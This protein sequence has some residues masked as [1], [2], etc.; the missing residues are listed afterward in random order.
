MGDVAG[1]NQRTAE[2]QARLD[3][4]F[5]KDRAHLV[6]ALVEV[7]IHGGRHGGSL[8]R[9]ETCGILF[10]FFEE[11]A[12]RGDL[13][14]DVTVGRAAHADG[15]GARSRMARG[16]DHAHVVHEVF[17]A[18]LGADAALLADF[19]HFIFPL[20]VAE[21]AAALVARGG[22][23]VE[24]TGRSLLHRREAHLGRRTADAD[25]QVVRRTG[26]RTEVED[27][28]FDEFRERLLV[29]ERL[30]LLVKKRLVGRTAALGDEQELVF[31]AG[32]AAVDVDLGGKVRTRV[33]LFGHRLRNDLRIT[34]VTALIGLVNAFGDTLGI[35]GPRVNVLALMADADSRAGILAGRQFAFGRN[36]LVQ[37]HRV[38]HELVV[39][40]GFGVLE[41]VA[42]L[43]EVR[44]AQVKRHVGISLFRKQFEALGVD[45][46]DFASVALDDLHVLLRQKTVLGFVFPHGERLL[47]NKVCHSVI[48]MLFVLCCRLRPASRP[49]QGRICRQKP[50][51]MFPPVTG[52]SPQIYKKQS[53]L[54]N[55]FPPGL[56]F[57]SQKTAI[58]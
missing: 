22:Q 46:E 50:A 54:H 23:F 26:R 5:R 27:M 58:I 43:F 19:Q 9:Q 42:Q 30:G 34:Q 55:Y 3:R 36:D 37:Q 31:H 39:V 12:R 44:G 35:V 52:K 32:L 16:T 8:G 21:A 41:D 25:R 2:V 53:G 6:H 47:I 13:G 1:H 4:V 29:Q 56:L 14:L 28:L 40:G 51:A 10:E 20:Q 11:D 7:D 57:F 15:H 33:F 38:G 24:V 48:C 45:L 49:E 18:E 17:A